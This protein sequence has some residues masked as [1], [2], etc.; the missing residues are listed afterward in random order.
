MTSQTKTDKRIELEVKARA[1]GIKGKFPLQNATLIAKIDRVL[2][3]KLE[4][5]EATEEIEVAEVEEELEVIATP[6]IVEEPVKAVAP[7]RKKAPSMNVSS[8]NTDVRTKAIERL[9]REDPECIY[10][11]QNSS[12]SDKDLAAKGMERTG[13]SVKNDIICRT[14]RKSYEG[15][16]NAKNEGQYEAM[17]R[18]DGGTGIVGSYQA[19]PKSPK[20]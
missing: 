13:E 17:Q 2:S 18:I 14:T 3:E 5:P 6:E 9:E 10:I 19:R 1:L 12:I 16:L 4:E 7:E 20:S 15:V 11:F 8:V